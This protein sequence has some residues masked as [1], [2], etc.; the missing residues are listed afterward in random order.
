MAYEIEL[1][2]RVKDDDIDR[3]RKALIDIPGA[4]YH[5]IN[6]KFDM[7]W[8][9]TDDGEPLFRTRREITEK[10]PHVLFTAK[11]MKTKDGLG[12]EENKEL[13]FTASDDQWD[14][15]LQFYS[16]IGLQVCRLKWKKGYDYMFCIDGFDIHAELL[17]VRFL[18]WFLE[19]EIC[20]DTLEGVD[21][22]AA[23]KALRKALALV[24]ISEEAIEPTGYN[25][26]LM[27]IGHD[28]G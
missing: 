1:K 26:M 8:S 4:S 14:K 9:Q 21:K 23:D 3:V 2:A 18:G 16:G 5:G 15:I 20:L 25:K 13:E 12:I 27:A 17:D 11:P 22:E 19:M 6:N 24:D 10:G 7:Y 28:K